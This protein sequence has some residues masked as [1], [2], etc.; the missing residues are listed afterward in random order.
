[1]KR[2]G[3]VYGKE[4]ILRKNGN[5]FK[6]YL[7]NELIGVYDPN[8]MEDRILFREDSK[9]N[10]LSA[11]I[12]D[13]VQNIVDKQNEEIFQEKEYRKEEVLELERQLDFPKKRNIK[14]ITEIDLA[15]KVKINEEK[16]S[17]VKRI[18]NNTLSKIEN[19]NTINDV[20]VKQEMDLDNKTTDMKRLGQVLEAAGKI[21]KDGKKYEKLG[22][23][24][25]DE[26]NKTKTE[27]GKT[28]K[29]NTTRYQFVLIDNEGNK[30]PIDLEQDY[31]EGDNPREENYS[32]NANGKLEENS[33]LSRYKIGEGTLAIDN[34]QYGEIKTYYSPRKT[35]GGEGVEGNK[36]LDTE[37][38]TTNVWETDKKIRDISGEYNTGYRSV[39][40]GY[41]E[42][43]KNHKTREEKYCEELR[44]E[45]VDGKNDTSSHSHIHLDEDMIEKLA[46]EILDE[47]EEIAN[48]YNMEDIKEKLSKT[49]EERKNDELNTEQLKEEVTEKA[50]KDS[51]FE[52]DKPTILH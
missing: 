4:L 49:I 36:S 47:N 22:I 13:K 31:Q 28:V 25:S 6:Y 1:M 41:Q 46:R 30:T 37:L 23:V 15:Q 38:E 17:K 32:I 51:E 42:V 11:E 12:K 44:S 50:E 24:E 14:R 43:E 39:E 45:D 26:I 18:N 27:D 40:E 21:P 7:D 33:V 10:S 5:I 19:N 8:V 2:L 48:V 29:G 52:H 9:E 35:I 16:T 20:N 34:E 3:T